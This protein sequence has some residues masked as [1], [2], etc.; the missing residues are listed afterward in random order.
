MV[1]GSTATLDLASV[2]YLLF[3]LM[4]FLVA[5]VLALAPLMVFSWKGA[6]YLALLML[7]LALTSALGARVTALTSALGARVTALISAVLGR[8][9]SDWGVSSESTTGVRF[10]PVCT[11]FV[12]GHGSQPYSAAAPLDLALLAFSTLYLF[13]FI[14]HNDLGQYYRPVQIFFPSATFAYT[15]FLWRNKCVDMV[16]VFVALLL[17]AAG[18]W[19]GGMFVAS[20]F[21]RLMYLAA[22]S[23]RQSCTRVK[24]DVYT[25]RGGDPNR[26]A[27][28]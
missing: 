10:N 3:R 19:L 6:P 25:C 23:S 9:N 5:T 7:T 18:G 4:P 21:P 2:S 8:I 22:P 13:F 27:D 12:I 1:G 11:S 17:G 26:S 14:E 15:L 20:T 24:D 28:K 16:H